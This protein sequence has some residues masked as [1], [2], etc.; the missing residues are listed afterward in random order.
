MEVVFLTGR[1]VDFEC[2]LLC[3]SVLSLFY[4]IIKPGRDV[5]ELEVGDTC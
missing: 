4:I 3:H 1:S 2:T 5:A